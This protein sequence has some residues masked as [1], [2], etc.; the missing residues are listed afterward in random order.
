[1]NRS[2]YR[3]SHALFPP[4]R[5]HVWLVSFI[6]GEVSLRGARVQARGPRD[7]ITAPEI[8]LKLLMLFLKRVNIEH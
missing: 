2:G 1:M 3:S 7:L 4:G 5:K 8:V 6:R